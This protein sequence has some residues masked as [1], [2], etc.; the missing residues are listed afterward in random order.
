MNQEIP[1]LDVET[2]KYVMEITKQKMTIYD[3]CKCHHRK[4]EKM[5]AY[6]DGKMDG[7][8]AINTEIYYLIKAQQEA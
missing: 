4:R 2:L 7:V 6:Y 1:K 5:Y 3:N 8:C